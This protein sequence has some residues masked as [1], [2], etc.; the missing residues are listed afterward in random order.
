L[1]F[2]KQ[3]LAMPRLVSDSPS[4]CLSLMSAGNYKC[5]GVLLVFYLVDQKV[6][7][8]ALVSQSTSYLKVFPQIFLLLRLWFKSNKSLFPW[9]V[10]Y[11][12]S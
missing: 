4:S 5:A 7:I 11:V 9:N 8:A 6:K 10:F 1:F 3:G 12:S 2:L